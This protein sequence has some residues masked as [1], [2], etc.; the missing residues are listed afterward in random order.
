MPFIDTT[1]AETA[2]KH[3]IHQR[4]WR[5]DGD[6]EPYI[7]VV[8]DVVD[9]TRG[10]EPVRAVVIQTDPTVGLMTFEGEFVEPAMYGQIYDTG[11]RDAFFHWCYEGAGRADWDQVCR[12]QPRTG[13]WEEGW[14]MLVERFTQTN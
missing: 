12:E 8:L 5:R 2:G 9:C 7:P 13:P 3:A 6:V 10:Q 1:Q 4:F 11:V 14:R